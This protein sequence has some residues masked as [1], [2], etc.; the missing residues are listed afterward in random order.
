VY[1]NNSAKDFDLV[2]FG[3][4]TL[5]NPGA[6]VLL[7]PVNATNSFLPD[8]SPKISYIPPSTSGIA[9]SG[10][11]VS[12]VN[13]SGLVLDSVQWANSQANAIGDILY[14]TGDGKSVSRKVIDS[15]IVVTSSPKNDFELL[16]VPTPQ[17]GDPLP[18]IVP[19]PTPEPVPDPIPNLDVPPVPVD[20][21]IDP[22]PDPNPLPEPPAPEPVVT[23]VP[24]ITPV[25]LP[26]LLNELYIDPVTPQSDANDEWVELY[27]PNSQAVDVSGYAVF[28]GASY[29]YKYV[30]PAGSSIAANGYIALTSGA[31]PL[32]LSNGGSS[33][34]IVSPDSHVFDTV[35]YADAP[36]GQAW[37]KNSSNTWE[38]TT[39]PTE[40]SINTITS[41]LPPAIKAAAVAS[42]K[43]S[44]KSTAATTKVT[45]VKA[46]TTKAAAKPKVV[47]SSSFEEPT[48]IA[49]PMPIPVWLL[50]V[51]IGLAVLYVGYEYRFEVA[52]SL[53]RFRRYRNARR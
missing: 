13:A 51:L 2:T 52:N 12:I 18:V 3:L 23:D 42:T 41:P 11:K 45:A 20:P 10:G 34:K 38:W 8:I 48:L 32:S 47:A 15:K 53:Y 16:I 19:E 44:T 37:A 17:T 27:N 9:A 40:E 26:I 24:S 43:A 5:V 1:T 46:A 36:A 4:D 39:T 14:F 30:F 28:T 31:T 7:S 21:P 50:A 35:S 49:A 29:S 22:V 6:F 33:A 25:Y